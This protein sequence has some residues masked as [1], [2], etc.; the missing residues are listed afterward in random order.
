MKQKSFVWQLLIILGVSFSTILL[1]GL[2]K[3]EVTVNP[4][5]N[6]N[7]I[8]AEGGDLEC[9]NKDIIT[10]CD[11]GIFVF[12]TFDASSNFAR[13][14]CNGTIE[15]S[16]VGRPW[17]PRAAVYNDF[18]IP[19]SPDNFV[20]VQ[21]SITYDFEGALHG[22]VAYETAAT[23]T[24]RVVDVTSDNRPD[25]NAGSNIGSFELFHQDRSGDQG[26]TPSFESEN[27]DLN[28]ANSS[29]ILKLR[30]G[31]T[32]RIWFEAEALAELFIVGNARASSAAA[33]KKLSVWVDEDEVE[34]ISIHDTDV[35]SAIT[36]HDEDI[37]DAIAQYDE[38]IKKELAGIK[39][40]L[41]EIKLLLIT[42]QGRRP[43][44]A[45]K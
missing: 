5:E 9:R 15:T 37:K 43:G 21:I 8:N 2:A 44:F 31:R 3:A 41:E 33:W 28:D 16:G 1:M 29:L 38:D 35:K 10:D 32:Y 25:L 20:D 17:I 22:R 40:D 26:L 27:Y 34:Q 23:V 45:N 7:F 13:A 24:L 39:D 30:R 6:W 19:G 11:D 42:P 12:T 14:V 4:G 36:E 18:S